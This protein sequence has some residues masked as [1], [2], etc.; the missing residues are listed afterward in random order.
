MRAVR[1]E[2]PGELR[3]IDLPDATEPGRSEALVR[4]HR[5]GVCGTDLHAYQGHQPF[6]SYPR[7]LG[8]ELGV[9]VVAI[10]DGVASVAVG[11]RCSV[12][13]YLNCG[14]CATCRRGYSNACVRLSVLGVHQ[15]GGLCDYLRVPSAKLHRS[16]HL[17]FD[18]L[19]L[20]ETLAIGA[21]AVARAQVSAGEHVLV[22]GAGPIGLT[23]VQ[24][25][26]LAG[27]HVTVLDTNPRRLAFCREHFAIERGIGSDDLPGMAATPLDDMPTVVFDA[28]GNAGSMMATFRYLAHG[29][30]LVFVGLMQGDITFNDPEFHRREVT[31]LASRNALSSDFPRII[32]LLEAGAI[33]LSTWVTH[34]ATAEQMIAN[35]ATWLTPTAGVVKAMVHMTETTTRQS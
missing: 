35:F 33:R 17:S 29:G 25:A 18:E 31:L 30:R 21:H 5:V 3:L 22:V 24:F 9:E 32:G 7:I 27:A 23:V 19:A 14:E 13:P 10:G 12:E 11:D 1:L 20:V 4:V 15:D 34:M 28:T 16:P 6:F 26:L 8:H 2:K